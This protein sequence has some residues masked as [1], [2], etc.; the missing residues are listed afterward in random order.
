MERGNR[1][2]LWRNENRERPPSAHIEDLVQRATGSL[3][4][5]ETMSLGSAPD[6][7]RQETKPMTEV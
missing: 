2:E 3:Q 5:S 1:G 7:L 4:V 6:D